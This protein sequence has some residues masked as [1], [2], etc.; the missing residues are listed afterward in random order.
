MEYYL[1]VPYGTHETSFG[2]VGNDDELYSVYV[3]FLDSELM[4]SRQILAY[5]DFPENASYE[6]VST[7]WAKK[8][9]G[10]ENEFGLEFKLPDDRTM[11]LHIYMD[12]LQYVIHVNI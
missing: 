5:G 12:E 7:G 8:Q 2:F 3:M 4:N 10:C 11:K 9:E 6:E 1:N